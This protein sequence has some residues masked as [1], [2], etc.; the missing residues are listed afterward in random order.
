M[1]TFT[2]DTNC[3]IALDE[4]RAEPVA[5]RALGEAHRAGSADG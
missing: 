5:I 4:Q 2:L 1:T 3:I